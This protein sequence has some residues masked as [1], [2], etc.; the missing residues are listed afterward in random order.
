[1]TPEQ[2]ETLTEDVARKYDLAR[3]AFAAYWNGNSKDF[4]KQFRSWVHMTEGL[5]DHL[6]DPDA[7]AIDMAC[8]R[9]GVDAKQ[10]LD[11]WQAIVR[12]YR[13]GSNVAPEQEG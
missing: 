11:I 6:M 12:H 5:L 1:M 8:K 13:Y 7:A 3:V 4:E 2:L 9:A 10:A